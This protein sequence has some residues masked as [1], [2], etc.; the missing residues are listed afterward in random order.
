MCNKYELI[1]NVHLAL[2]K[3]TVDG[4]SFLTSSPFEYYHYNCDGF[5]DVVK[6]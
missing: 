1:K 4:H 3:P 6:Y 2:E 5:N